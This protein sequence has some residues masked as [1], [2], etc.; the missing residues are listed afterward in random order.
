MTHARRHFLLLDDIVDRLQHQRIFTFSEYH[1]ALR[2]ARGIE[3]RFHEQAGAEY[4]GVQFLPVG[5]HVFDRAF[6][7]PRIHRRL[8]HRRRNLE[9]Q[10]A[11]ER[12]GNQVL[13]PESQ[14]LAVI[15]IGDDIA[16]AGM[17]QP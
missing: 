14:R 17:R 8:R 12:F 3:D 6:G 5:A 4:E 16:G 9:D 10:A 11:V 15:S 1:A 13:W 7:H 2:D